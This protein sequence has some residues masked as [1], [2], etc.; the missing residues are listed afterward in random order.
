MEQPASKPKIRVELDKQSNAELRRIARNLNNAFKIDA[1][2]TLSRNNLLKEIR[3]ISSYK[4]SLN[5]EAEVQRKRERLIEKTEQNLAKLKQNMDMRMTDLKKTVEREK[6]IQ[7]EEDL[8]RQQPAPQATVSA[9]TPRNPYPTPD[10]D[11]KTSTSVGGK[12]KRTRRTKR[13]RK[14]RFTRRHK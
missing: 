5:P 8:Q 13:R 4:C 6:M 2:A 7:M 14:A 10:S 11:F 9:P 3:R 12:S 1:V